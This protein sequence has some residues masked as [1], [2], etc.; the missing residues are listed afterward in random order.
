MGDLAGDLGGIQ[1]HT[2]AAGGTQ[3]AG[4]GVSVAPKTEYRL[5]IF[6][7]SEARRDFTDTDA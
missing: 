1:S 3:S 5:L 6:R 7:A 2:Q 4:G